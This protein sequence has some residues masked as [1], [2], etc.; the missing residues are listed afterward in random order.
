MVR[1]TLKNRT[2]SDELLECLGVES[3]I[4]VIRRGRLRWF[5]HLE[6]KEESNWVATCRNLK[7][8]DKKGR[9]R[10]RKTSLFPY[11]LT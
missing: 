4:D 2:R 11:F 9:G 8:G 1:W 5:A 6:S 7:V 3:I 10:G